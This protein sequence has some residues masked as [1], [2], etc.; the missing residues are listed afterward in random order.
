MS[1]LT[2]IN[3]SHPIALFSYPI[4]L[5]N[6][7]P[8]IF[9]IALFNKL[10]PI[11]FFNQSLPSASSNI[12]SVA[13]NAAPLNF[14]TFCINAISVII[15]LS[16]LYEKITNKKTVSFGGV[17]IY[18]PASESA[19]APVKPTTVSFTCPCCNNSYPDRVKY[20]KEFNGEWFC[21]DTCNTM[22]NTRQRYAKQFAPQCNTAG[23]LPANPALQTVFPLKVIPGRYSSDG[24]KFVF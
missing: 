6:A 11:A 3:K 4:A 16:F 13:L 2:Y 10:F 18:A 17:T 21:G 14:F 12:S 19:S 23:F 5:Y 1:L 22:Y 7:V 15:I 9:P 24:V 20:G 8:S